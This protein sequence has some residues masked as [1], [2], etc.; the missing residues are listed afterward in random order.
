MTYGGDAVVVDY[1]LP[2]KRKADMRRRQQ[3]HWVTT[4]FEGLLKLNPDIADELCCCYPALLQQRTQARCIFRR[5]R[6][7]P[8][9]EKKKNRKD[10]KEDANVRIPKIGEESATTLYFKSVVLAIP[11]SLS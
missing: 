7:F 3:Q 8:L 1:Y 10:A 4:L 5:E 2:R 6:P 9:A 11:R